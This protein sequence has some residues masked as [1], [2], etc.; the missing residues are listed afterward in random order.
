MTKA[1]TLAVIGGL[2]A[3]LLVL[4][5]PSLI[6][7]AQWMTPSEA[8]PAD[9]GDNASSSGFANPILQARFA[10]FIAESREATGAPSFSAAIARNG[11]LVWAGTNGLASIETGVAATPAHLYRLGST[12]K[13]VTAVLLGRMIDAGGIDLSNTI[14]ELAPGLPDHLAD[15]TIRQLA[16]HTAGIRH[17]SRIPAWIPDRNESIT[18][19]HFPSVEAGLQMF[20]DDPLLFEPGEGFSYSTFGFSLLSYAMERAGGTNFG[21]LLSQYV[22]LP[23]GVDLRLD[24]LTID[25]PDRASTYT[26]G[27][28]KWTAAYPSDPSDKWAGGGIVASPRDLAMIGQAMLAKGFLSPA[29]RAA[30]WSPVALPG[31]DSNPQNYG[32]GWRIDTSTGTLGDDHPVQVIH[33]GGAQMGGVAFWAIYP[34][35]GISVAVAAN[36]GDR[37]ARGEVQTTAYALV[38][39]L[40]ADE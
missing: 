12:S 32:L 2:L 14:G 6:F 7:W 35:L 20:V 28:G 16:S 11:K 1:R 22:S 24:D 19:V 37:Q 39:A 23:V 21:A 9:V 15:I 4:T 38:R 33:H 26:T 17:Y 36:T 13:A 29:T 8:L 31:A 40:V 3:V 5:G 27:D 30:L 10:G 18:A 25:M 34:E